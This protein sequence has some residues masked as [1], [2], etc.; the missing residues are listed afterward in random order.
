MFPRLIE[1][2]INGLLDVAEPTALRKLQIF[3][4]LRSNGLFAGDIQRFSLSVDEFF[5]R[6]RSE[7]RK[8][9]FDVYL[10]RPMDHQVFS[11]FQL[12][13]RVAVV[14][15][16]TL[17]DLASWAFNLIRV[18]KK[19]SN[20]LMGLDV[21]LAALKRVTN[22]S[23]LE[24][25]RDIEFKDFCAAWKRAVFTLF[26]SDQDQEFNSLLQ[27]LSWLDQ[28][29]KRA[30]R[31][32]IE[33]ALVPGIYLTQTEIDWTI[34]VHRAASENA[35]APKFPLSRG[36]EKQALKDLER[37]ALLYNS[38]RVSNLPEIVKNRDR[39]LATV[40]DRCEALLGRERAE[41]A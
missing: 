39:I 35:E 12:D 9:Q 4:A 2:N 28:E 7:R 32:A 8:S 31:E 30:E 1:R 10:D 29:S 40:L 17:R 3:R 22:P 23:R 20:P 34:A 38:A 41:G 18:N 19:T 25:A 36:P 37:V 33:T 16:Q 14:P 21:I 24:K 13:F 15:D 11:L 26:G 5:S 6:P 27:E